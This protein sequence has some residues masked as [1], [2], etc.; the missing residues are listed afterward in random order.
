MIAEIIKKICVLFFIV[1][2]YQKTAHKAIF[3]GSVFWTESELISKKIRTLIFKK[4]LGRGGI[5]PH[6]LP[7]AAPS[8]GPANFLA[9]ILNTHHL[10][11]FLDFNLIIYF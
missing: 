7:S 9:K 8:L 3:T 2:F 11:I 10:L 4:P 5:P 1:L 6:T